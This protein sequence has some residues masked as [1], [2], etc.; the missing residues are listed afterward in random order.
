M[1]TDV[2]STCTAS[3]RTCSDWPLII[4]KY[5]FISSYDKDIKPIFV[6]S[7]VRIVKQA[8]WTESDSW[9]MRN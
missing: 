4:C 8:C 5:Y 6:G 3:D 2:G 1:E 7:R 9:L